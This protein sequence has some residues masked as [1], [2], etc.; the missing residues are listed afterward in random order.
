MAFGIPGTANSTEDT[1]NGDFLP[2][3]KF[4][5]RTGFWVHTTRFQNADGKWE[6]NTSDFYR[7]PSFLMDFASLEVGYAKIDTPPVFVMVG[8]GKPLPP[9][10]EEKKRNDAGKEVYSFAPAAR[11]RVMGS[12]F[13][14]N[15]V[16]QFTIATKTGLPHLEEAF[17][18]YLHAPEAA[19]GQ[20]PVVKA[21][22]KKIE[23]DTPKGKNT[24]YAPTFTFVSW[25]DRPEVLGTRLVTV[26]SAA[27][28]PA[29]EAP[30]PN[31][32]VP[33]PAAAPAKEPLPF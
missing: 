21:S 27:P 20:V 7:D 19:A 4:D 5:A 12:A 33:P 25:L 10:P 11:L 3:V 29:S 24:Y 13:G 23:V 2:L 32:H 14:D 31:G 9:R 6:T 18:A 8:Y 16:R 1:G 17:M 26:G 22:T 15:L 28:A 30:K